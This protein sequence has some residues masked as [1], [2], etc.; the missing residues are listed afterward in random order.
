MVAI[1]R[2]GS[3]APGLAMRELPPESGRAADVSDAATG[4]PV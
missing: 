3:Q 4:M 1:V 2:G